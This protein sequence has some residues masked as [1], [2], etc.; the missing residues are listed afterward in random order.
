[1]FNRAS[2]ELYLRDGR[3]VWVYG[4]PE[5]GAALLMAVGLV[6]TQRRVRR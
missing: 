5:P 2:G 1:V 4:V 3:N 6:M